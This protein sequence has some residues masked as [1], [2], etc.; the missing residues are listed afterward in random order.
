[1][2]NTICRVRGKPNN[3]ETDFVTVLLISLR[4][5]FG[6]FCHEAKFKFLPSRGHVRDLR[7]EWPR[8]QIPGRAPAQWSRSRLASFQWAAKSPGAESTVGHRRR[9]ASP[10][11]GRRP[12]RRRRSA[13]KPRT[14][15]MRDQLIGRRLSGGIIRM[16]DRRSREP[17]GSTSERAEFS[18]S[19]PILMLTLSRQASPFWPQPPYARIW[20]VRPTMRDPA[21]SCFTKAP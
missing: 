3:A 19:S 14:M 4:V 13:G 21:V 18:A 1:M 10:A 12:R 8:A 5:I 16:P 2:K 7:P 11:T 15:E 9:S 17:G 20:L 6:E